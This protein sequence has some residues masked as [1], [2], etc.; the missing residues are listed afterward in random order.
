MTQ[1]DKTQE[2]DFASRLTAILNGGALNLALGIG[3]R[4]GL[5]E[6]MDKLTAPATPEDIAKEAKLSARYVKEWLGVVAT[7]K[8]VDVERDADG[9][10]RFFLPASHGDF[11]TKRAK[12]N[13]MGVYMQEIPLL[14]QCA[15]NGV[16]MGF[17][18]GDG[19][20]YSHYPAFQA[21]MGELADAK[22]KQVLVSEFLPWVADGAIFKKLEEGIKVADVGCGEG[23]A[24]ILMAE[25][26]P[27]SHFTGLDISSEALATA[28]HQ[29]KC[30]GLTNIAFIEQDCAAID[31]NPVFENEFDYVTAFDAIHDQTQPL[32]ALKGIRWMLKEDG[33]FSMIDIAA[34]TAISDNADHPM[35]PFL[36]TVSLMHC[37]PVGLVNNGTGLGMMWG[38]EKALEMLGQAGFACADAQPIPND[39]FN[40][41]FLAH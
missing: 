24:V 14:T 16:L 5:F 10:E 37:M 32:A 18:T 12:N 15:M 35:A 40:L 22:H 38:K 31:G 9:V 29:A 33:L 36:Y 26:F 6:V 41:H 28:R 2:Q 11:L 3:Y 20:A 39:G 13:N 4:L 34:S 19:V 21:F 17:K 27:N 8:I 1:N 7:G 30:R 23:L 25:R